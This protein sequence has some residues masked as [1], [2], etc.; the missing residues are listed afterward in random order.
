M[1]NRWLGLFIVAAWSSMM[2]STA[3]AAMVKNDLLAGV[4][5]FEKSTYVRWYSSYMSYDPANDSNVMY[6]LLP[7][8]GQRSGYNKPSADDSVADGWIR[9]SGTNVN[10]LTN[11]IYR[12]TNNPNL[13]SGNCQ[14]MGLRNITSEPANVFLDRHVLVDNTKPW[15]LHTGDTVTFRIDRIKM[16]D[17][18][19]LPSGV[20]VSYSM[21]LGDIAPTKKLN[22][23]STAFSAEI[24]AVIPSGVSNINL[25]VCIITSGK[26]GTKQPGIYIDGAHLYVKRANT[27]GYEMIEVPVTTNRN[28]STHNIGYMDSW[29]DIYKVARDN[30]VLVIHESNYDSI[31]TL[32]YYKPGMKLY[33][34]ESGASFIDYRDAL[35]KDQMFCSSPITF[36][37]AKTAHPNWLYAGG[38]YDY[39]RYP[40]FSDR[41]F[42]RVT[43]SDYQNLWVQRVLE[44]AAKLGVNGIWI[45]DLSNLRPDKHGVSRDIWE[46]QQFLH[47]V[48]PKLKAAGLDV[49][50]NACAQHIQNIP[51]AVGTP[52]DVWFS[53]LW[54][55]NDTYP[56]TAGYSAN[57][58]ANTPDIF[59]QEWAFFMP[60]TATKNTYDRTYWYRCIQDMDTIVQWNTATDT[61]GAPLL[62]TNQKRRLHMFVYGRDFAGDSAFGVDGWLQ[63]GFASFLLG[64]NSWTSLGCSVLTPGPS[65]DV[66]VYPEMDYAI[67]QKL[68]VPDGNH[69]A[70]GGDVYFR[71]R[72]YKAAVAGGLDGG[73]V[74]VNANTDAAKTY[75]L[76]FA[77]VDESGRSLPAG[78]RIVVKPHTGRILIRSVDQLVIQIMPSNNSVTPGQV[79]D[80]SVQYSNKGT[81]ALRSILVKAQVPSDMTYVKGSAERTGGYYNATTQ[82]VNWLVLNLRAGA[83]G[84]KAF[85]AKVK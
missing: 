7:S 48:C 74:V 29:V 40:E 58:P 46:I 69:Q 84:S 57:N 28:I 75:V 17:Y 35:G 39:Y 59:F 36:L 76:G 43:N 37:E 44:K 30:D 85:K 70:I 45:D 55:P 62:G 79:I 9:V 63:F 34:Y 72:R 60:V 12:V 26:L 3:L 67:T 81:S 42:A 27:V 77:A 1:I 31:A 83:T 22:P 20:R 15:R 80:I 61:S 78:S 18:S 10:P 5:Q 19:G 38:D 32:R 21:Q 53:P 11:I 33:M 24:S 64:Q 2:G 16:S 49:I 56:A 8:S 68:G 6:C 50:E 54:T 71:Y 23:S 73:V 13:G 47:V 41:Y 52:L 82:T 51:N 65:G 66:P 14:F 25:Q 4:G